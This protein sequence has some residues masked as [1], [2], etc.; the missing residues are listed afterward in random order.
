MNTNRGSYLLG[1]VL[2]SALVLTLASNAMAADIY[3]A[4]ASRAATRCLR[5]LPTDR[6]IYFKGYIGQANPN[7]GSIFTPA[8]D[9]DNTFTV[10]HKD[11][12]SARCSASASAGKRSHWLRF[13]LTGEYRGDAVFLGQDRYLRS[14]LPRRHERVHGRHQEL[15]GLANA[16]WDIGN[17]CGFTPY[18]GAG[19][20]FATISVDGLKDVN[21]PQASVVLRCRQHD[22]ELRLGPARRRQ[23]RRHS[24]VRVDLCLPLCQSRQAKSGV[25]TAYDGASSYSGLHIRDITSNDLMLGFRYKLD[26]TSRLYA[27]K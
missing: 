5:R 6:G 12:K 21:V 18:V 2:G 4:P 24:A 17:W 27:I 13:D 22:H 25:V 11:I 14:C 1:A 9:T 26:G 8:Y 3:D 15:A 7:V 10:F 23:L 20:G 19:I 16:Y